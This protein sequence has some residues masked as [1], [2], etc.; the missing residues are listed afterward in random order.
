MGWS[1]QDEQLAQEI[2]ARVDK[3]TSELKEQVAVL[4]KERNQAIYR[5]QRMELEELPALVNKRDTIA[6][7]LGTAQ[8]VLV[9]SQERIRAAQVA[10]LRDA[11]RIPTSR[12]KGGFGGEVA[13]DIRDAISRMADEL[14][15]SNG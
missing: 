10:V 3:E 12:W 4:T 11:A 5:M 7:D 6:I 9:L 14:E 15:K 8:A 2:Q 13:F 1:E